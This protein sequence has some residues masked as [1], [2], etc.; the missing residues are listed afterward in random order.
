MGSAF[1]IGP[2][3]LLLHA[4]RASLHG[5]AGTIPLGLKRPSSPESHGRFRG[6]ESKLPK[7]AARSRRVT[8]GA[9]ASQLLA[10]ARSARIPRAVRTD[11]KNFGRGHSSDQHFRVRSRTLE[12]AENFTL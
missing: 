8:L 5:K 9:P 7:S 12:S 11:P 6:A 3:P 2:A 1:G 4:G 10:D